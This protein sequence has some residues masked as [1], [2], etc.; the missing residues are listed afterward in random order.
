MNKIEENLRISNLISKVLLGVITAAEQQE[1]DY[2]LKQSPD[3]IKQ[4][5]QIKD[6]LFASLQFQREVNTKQAWEQQKGLLQY[7]SSQKWYKNSWIQRVAAIFLILA[8][9]SVF[10]FRYVES[11]NKENQKTLVHGSEPL[12]KVRKGIILLHNGEAKELANNQSDS[13]QYLTRFLGD[14]KELNKKPQDINTL[15]VPKGA[16]LKVV[17]PDGTI[18]WLNSDSKL[19]FPNQFTSSS[20]V[21]QV[22]GEVCLDVAPRK[23]QSFIVQTEGQ[24]IKVLGTLFNIEAYP[25]SPTRTTLIRGRVEIKHDN[26]TQVLSPNQQFVLQE[27]G[28][29][30]ISSINAQ[31]VIKW[32]TGE[33][34]F[35]D[36]PLS[37]IM[38][39][40]SRWYDIQYS[41]KSAAAKNARFTIQVSRD[42]SLQSLL[43]KIEMTGRVRFQVK[44]K[45]IHIYD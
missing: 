18:A 1:L 30:A 21:I 19:S 14:H 5:Q 15:I 28:K 6:E 17:L 7:Q 29:S 33:F 22:Q 8:V 12:K 3:H 41:F 24:Q 35:T 45:S 10:Y 32:T 25:S 43:K 13:A 39:R 36:T 16:E 37:L 44:D 23:N 20:R 31:E 34:E 40:F 11:S 38:Q 42:E 9:A 26:Q 2:W 27:D 4:Y